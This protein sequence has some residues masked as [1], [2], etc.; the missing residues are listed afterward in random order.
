MAAARSGRASSLWGLVAGL[1]PLAWGVWLPVAH[2]PYWLP[3][4]VVVWAWCR[5]VGS[6]TLWRRLSAFG[7]GKGMGW[8]RKLRVCLQTYE[9]DTLGRRLP[10]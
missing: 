9:G 5:L 4:L 3:L 6:P 10:C 1:L 7:F 8:R 2:S